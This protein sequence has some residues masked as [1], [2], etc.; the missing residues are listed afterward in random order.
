VKISNVMPITQRNDLPYLSGIGQDENDRSPIPTS[1]RSKHHGFEL[2]M[3]SAPPP[4][5]LDNK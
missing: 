2:A 1:L 5:I 4:T 3:F